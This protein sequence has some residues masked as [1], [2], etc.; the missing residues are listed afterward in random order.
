MA[1]NQLFHKRCGCH[2]ARHLLTATGTTVDVAFDARQKLMRKVATLVF[3]FRILYL[4]ETTCSKHEINKM[5]VKLKRLLMES[6]YRMKGKKDD[7]LLQSGRNP[8]DD[9]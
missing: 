4:W 1:T 7:E 2:I 5:C 3:F 6:V 8:V 9:V